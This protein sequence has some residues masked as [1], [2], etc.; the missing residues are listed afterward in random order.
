[1]QNTIPILSKEPSNSLHKIHFIWYPL[2]PFLTEIIVKQ[3]LE[4]LHFGFI[5][6]IYEKYQNLLNGILCLHHSL[7]TILLRPKSIRLNTTKK[8][9]Q[10]F[11]LLDHIKLFWRVK[12]ISVT[13]NIVINKVQNSL[14]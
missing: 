11:L 13:L 4:L 5:D 2:Q 10:L 1:M 9:Y 8:I 6:V 7:L 14:R 12:N 3:N